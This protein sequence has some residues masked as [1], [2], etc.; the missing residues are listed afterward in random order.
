MSAL[1]IE[2]AEARAYTIPTDRPESDGSL[3]WKETTLVTLHV[4]AG[5][6]VGFGYTYASKAAATLLRERLIPILEGSDPL[7][8][9]RRFTEMVARVRNDGRAGV[10]QMAIAAADSAL[11]D[12]KAKTLGL[13][14]A[15]LFGLARDHVPIYG[16]GGFTSY[17]EAEL[18]EQ[19]GGFAARGIPRVKMKV[20]RDPSRDVDRVKRAREA[21]GDNVELFVDGN[22]AYARKEALKMADRF[23]ALDV[24]WFEEPVSSDDLEG[25]RLLRDRAPASMDIAAGEYG[26]D[27]IYFRRMLASGAVDVLQADASRCGVTGFLQAAA[28]ADAFSI[29]LSAHCA[30]SLHL[31]PSCALPRFRHL[32]YFHDHARIEAMLFDGAPK[33][34]GGCLIPDLSRP[35][36]G[37]ELK[38]KD[39]APYEV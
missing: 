4:R 26:F 9:P 39:A 8:I 20:G 13:P 27:A 37:I 18:A 1:T 3:T 31:H 2:S 23:A 28:L 30:P 12:L 5:G 15:K 24:H 10:S 6:L 19:L 32:E 38:E 11:W 16:S 29:P 35:G 21:I 36:L 7:D 14:L 17:T 34:E 22:G 33:V 25:L